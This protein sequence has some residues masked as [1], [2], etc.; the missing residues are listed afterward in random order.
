MYEL[1]HSHRHQHEGSENGYDYVGLAK[2]QLA[3]ADIVGGTLVW[4]SS[5]YM[6]TSVKPVNSM[7]VLYL[8]N[9]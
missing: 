4:H 6:S 3:N 7:A 1:G 9:S 5:E 8:W 2:E